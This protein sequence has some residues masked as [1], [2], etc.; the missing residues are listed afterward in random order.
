MDFLSC[1]TKNEGPK[2]RA[3]LR[4]GRARTLPLRVDVLKDGTASGKVS[5]ATPG[6]GQWHRPA[7]GT[8]KRVLMI[9]IILR[10]GGSTPSP[11][12]ASTVQVV[13]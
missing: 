13:N 11:L 3:D 1:N 7:D 12:A 10:H 6:A 8:G 2:L 9:E 4:P 5:H